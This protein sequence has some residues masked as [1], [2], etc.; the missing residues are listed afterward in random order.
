MK[1]IAL[2][3]LSGGA[4]GYTHVGAIKVLEANGF[5]ITSIAGYYSVL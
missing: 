2:V 5:R 3:L 4:R 1:N